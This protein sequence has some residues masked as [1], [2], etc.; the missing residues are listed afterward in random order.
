MEVGWRCLG[1]E[2]LED[3]GE[4]GEERRKGTWVVERCGTVDGLQ[5]GATTMEICAKSS[6]SIVPG[7]KSG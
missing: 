4:G 1:L 7:S 3:Q 6:L 2:G 5:E